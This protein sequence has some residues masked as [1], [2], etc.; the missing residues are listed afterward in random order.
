MN[1][2]RMEDLSMSNTKEKIE[3]GYQ[4]QKRGYQ[5]SQ[6]KL[7]LTKPPEGGSGVPPKNQSEQGNKSKQNS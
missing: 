5:P 4:P 6:G 7:D 3:K 1:H 2:T